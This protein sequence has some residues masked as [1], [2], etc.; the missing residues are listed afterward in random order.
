MAKVIAFFTAMMT[1]FTMIFNPA[2][3]VEGIFSEPEATKE[4]VVFDEGEFTFGEND[5]MVSPEGEAQKTLP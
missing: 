3:P 4:Q 2:V 5:I 1:W